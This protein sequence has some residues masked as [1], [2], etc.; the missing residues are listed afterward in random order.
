MVTREGDVLGRS[1]EVGMAERVRVGMVAVWLRFSVL[2]GG[3]EVSMVL[4]GKG[5]L[6]VIWSW[7]SVVEFRGAL[8][9]QYPCLLYTSRCV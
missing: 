3:M 6:R 4:D 9:G 1:R 8:G 2:G 7:F 5:C